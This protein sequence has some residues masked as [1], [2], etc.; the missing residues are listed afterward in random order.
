MFSISSHKLS[1]FP[2]DYSIPIFKIFLESFRKTKGFKKV[3][4]NATFLLI[5]AILIPYFIF[6][7]LSLLLDAMYPI[8]HF[9]DILMGMFFSFFCMAS[10]VSLSLIALQYI[11]GCTVRYEM[12]LDLDK[13]WKP[14]IFFG[15]IIC[16]LSLCFNL[17]FIR[18]T[19]PNFNVNL[20]IYEIIS[21]LILFSYITIYS[22]QLAIMTILLIVDKKFNFFKSIAL[23]F[24]SINKHCFKNISLG[25]F[26]WLATLVLT[27]VTLG[28]GLIWLKPIQTI[29]YAIQYRRIFYEE[30][31]VN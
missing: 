18:M 31:S 23:S 9:K 14:L 15:F 27:I 1:K 6:V 11:Q 30:D 4:W 8:F 7:S 20:S 5:V 21:V 26:T 12:A 29:T 28:I 24:K 2:S 3:W 16:F 25:L 10:E 17:W 19:I 13:V 22:F